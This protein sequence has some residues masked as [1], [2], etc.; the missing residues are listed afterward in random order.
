LRAK[1]H[2]PVGLIERVTIERVTIERAG[3]ERATERATERI[4]RKAK[5]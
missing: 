5:P 2:L 3:T 4:R 1:L